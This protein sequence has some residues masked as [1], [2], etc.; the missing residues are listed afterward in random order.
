MT[1]NT[2]EITNQEITAGLIF[3]G[4]ETSPVLTNNYTT[5]NGV[6]GSTFNT[7]TIGQSVINAKFEL[8]TR[9]YYDMNLARHDI[10]KLFA[11]KDLFRIRT[12]ASPTKVA[13]VRA[14]SF[15]ITP[16][17]AGSR[18]ALITIPFDNP[19]GYLYSLLTSD[20][21]MTY[22]AQ[23]WSYGM[24]LPNGKDLNYHYNNQSQFSIYNASDVVI[25]PY[26]QKHQLA[27][28]IKHNGGSFYLDNK[29]TGDHY[30]FNGSLNSNDTLLIDGINTYKNNVLVD[31]Q[32]NYSY[33]TLKQ[34]FNELE[35]NATDLDILF[36]FPFIYLA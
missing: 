21:L 36:S 35:T 12:D 24:S 13:F 17:K 33:L 27:I 5:N 1:Q 34:G 7:T 15:D 6:D 20:N 10:Y 2:P 25:D 3:L 31:N 28:T 19:S 29:T 14:G 4:W 11:G 9:G 16:A 30:Q 8:F 23:G 22:E 26:Y 18:Q 32:T